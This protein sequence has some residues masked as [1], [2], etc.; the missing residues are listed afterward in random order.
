[1]YKN[2]IEIKNLGKMY[3]L[4]KK[5]SDKILDAFGLNFW[6]K[7]YYKEFWA[8]RDLNLDIKKGERIGLIGRNGAGKSTLL[9][10]IIGNIN[11]TEGFIKVNGKIQALMEL[12]TGFHPEFTGR[13]NIRASLAYQGLTKKQIV[14]KEEEIIEFSELEEFIDQPIRTYS[15]GMGARLAFS[16]AT[17]IEPEILIIDEVL[18][19]GDAYFAAKCVERMKKITENSGVTVLFVSHDLSSVQALCDRIIWID[20]GTIRADGEPLNI[21]K[22][23]AAEV[24]RNEEIRLKVRELKLSKKQA[25]IVDREEDLYYNLLF[26]FVDLKHKNPN[27]L[28]KIRTIKLLKG[29]Q[30][31]GKIEVGAPMDN[32]PEYKSFILD[33]SGLM[34]W[35]P[36]AKDELGYYRYYGNFN[37]KYGHAP[38]QISIPKSVELNEE[39]E[40]EILADCE[41]SEVRVEIYDWNNGQYIECGALLK[42]TTRNSFNIMS[43]FTSQN[44]N[45][46]VNTLQEICAEKENIKDETFNTLRESR[47]VRFTEKCKIVGVGIINKDGIN[48]K[49]FAFEKQ[50]CQMSFKLKFSEARKRFITTLLIFSSMGNITTSFFE[51]FILERPEE[52]VTVDYD[53]K[54]FRFG[55]GEYYISFAVYE[56]LDVLN[57]AVEQEAMAVID[58]GISFKVEKPMTFNL[59]IGN[60]LPNVN[61]KIREN[62]GGT[63][64]CR[65]LL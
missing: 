63:S 58:R 50:L 10:T 29:Q 32:N 6:K 41:N 27:G 22:Q 54:S 1:M 23:Y 47:D 3:K 11:P 40:L 19:A 60:V 26:R 35:G 9:K 61:I 45:L 5:S 38:F 36:V 57:N 25:A 16:T 18:G 39:V 37:G 65:T 24:R 48:S 17:A 53:F 64:E 14:E 15:A 51:E 62:K 30:E 2:A 42:G 13:E 4:Y 55:P 20:R 49:V 43:K 33:E 31:I 21:L 28:H 52:I 56:E 7:D 34:D 44:K 8:I 59:S 46:E 12:G